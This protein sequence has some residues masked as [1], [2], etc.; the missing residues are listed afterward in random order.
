MVAEPT[1]NDQIK[2]FFFQ[3]FFDPPDNTPRMLVNKAVLKVH[4]H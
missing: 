1:C 4:N 2:A 3:K